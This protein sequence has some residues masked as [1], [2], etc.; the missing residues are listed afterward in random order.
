[1]LRRKNF[2]L[3][4]AA[5]KLFQ[6]GWSEVSQLPEDRSSGRDHASFPPIFMRLK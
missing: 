5:N 1:M 2:V 4:T 3:E 6:A